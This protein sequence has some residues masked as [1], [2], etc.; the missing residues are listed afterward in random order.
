MVLDPFCGC[1][2]A[3]AVA[4]RLHRRWIGID[5]THLAVSL[6]KHRL[7]DAFGE[8]VAKTY[9]VVGEPVDLPGARALAAQDAYQFQWWTLGL[10]GAAR[11]AEEGRRQGH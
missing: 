8:E 11:P 10:V 7:H 6:I 1:G 9:N 5:V 2:T 3:I 4:Q